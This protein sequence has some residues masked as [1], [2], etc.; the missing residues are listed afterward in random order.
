MS[1]AEPRNG[2]KLHPFYLAHFDI[3]EKKDDNSNKY[4]TQ[5]KYC[6]K[7]PESKILH[8]DSR[9]LQHIT[10]ISACPNAPLHVRKEGLRMLDRKLSGQASEGLAEGGTEGGGKKRKTSP[11]VLETFLEKPIK[12]EAADEYHRKLLR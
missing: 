11:T 8:R 3:L 2:R 5:C 12:K 7:T 6:P 10:D 9:L 1:T 4:W